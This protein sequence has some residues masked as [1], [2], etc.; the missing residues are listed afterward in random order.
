MSTPRVRTSRTRAF[1]LI[2]TLSVI[3]VL[4]ILGS[5]TATLLIENVDAFSDASVHSRIH[6]DGSVT[7]DRIV[8]GIR[9]IDPD[10][11]DSD[12]PYITVAESGRLEWENG[13][14]LERTG[15]TLS[16][17]TD[18]ANLDVLATDV[19]AFSLAYFDEDNAALL[20]GGA[21]PAADLP[22]IRRVSISL[23]ITRDG[24]SESLR[25]RVFIRS[26]IGDGT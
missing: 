10:P 17:Q 12:A 21:V 1:T 4:G 24:R 26:M 22:T 3:V 11:A 13:K 15:T 2:E 16:I 23:T 19:T 25:T 7:L 18:G 8:R 6:A 5:I 20:S 9:A 14:V